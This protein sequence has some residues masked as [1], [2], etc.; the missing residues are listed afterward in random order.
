MREEILKNAPELEGLKCEIQPALANVFDSKGLD[1]FKHYLE[2]NS[3][4]FEA[5]YIIFRHVLYM[6]QKLEFYH[7]SENAL[8]LNDI[9]MAYVAIRNLAG[10]FAKPGTRLVIE[11]SRA[12]PAR[13]AELEGRGAPV[14]QFPG[15]GF[16]GTDFDSTIGIR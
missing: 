9:V 12:L 10:K 4:P 13:G 6:T 8:K 3:K 16:I 11:P 1:E 2:N 14:V 7:R 5:D 15:T